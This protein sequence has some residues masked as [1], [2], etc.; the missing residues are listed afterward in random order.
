MVD[1]VDQVPEFQGA[2]AVTLQRRRQHDPGGG[3]GVLTAVLADARHISFDVARLQGALVER[4]VEELDQF[5]VAAHQSFLNGVHCRSSPLRVRHA[6]DD[7]PG[8]RD[9][10]DLAFI[11]LG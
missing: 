3:M 7:R 4:R 8:L 2:V 10:V 9:R 6:G 11:V 5:V 1:R